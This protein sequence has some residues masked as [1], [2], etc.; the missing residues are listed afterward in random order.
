[1]MEEIV[2]QPTDD[3]FDLLCEDWSANFDPVL[4]NQVLAA[5]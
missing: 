5:I 3:Y 4:F 1:M 2:Q